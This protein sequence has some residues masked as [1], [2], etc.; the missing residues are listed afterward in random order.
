[1]SAPQFQAGFAGP[2]ARTLRIGFLC[3]HNPYDRSSF[4]GAPFHAA[5]ALAAVGGVTLRVIGG[6]RPRPWHDRLTRRFR[7]P[8]VFA[9]QPGE[10]EDLDVVVGLVA[11]GHLLEAATL[12]AA[13]LVHLTDATPDF[14][15][16]YYGRTVP[17]ERDLAEAKALSVVR[18]AVYSSD[19]MARRAVE[20]FG[21]HLR[22][23]IAALPFGANCALPAER[24]AKPQGGPLR[25]LWVGSQWE[26][27]GGAVALA[28]FDILRSRGQ[29][30]ELA[31]VG[32]VPDH[33][34][35][36][37]GLHLAGWL[38]KNR[39]AEAAQ[40]ADHFAAANLFILPTQA[41]CTPMVVAEAGAHGT[42]V[43]VTDVGGMGSLVAE[44]VNGRML[45]LEAGPTTWA[46]AIREMAADPA[47]LDALGASSF[48]H[49]RAHLTWDAWAE[50]LV[51]RL[52]LEVGADRLAAAAA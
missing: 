43:L 3:K 8:P 26:R 17:R 32:Q 18:L 47:A 1:M 49:V 36:R 9:L 12:T 11:T 42:P 16:E 10:F 20:E 39:P 40:L 31:M 51:A 38:D 4:S 28:A 15:R 2:L 13:P 45:P 44:G 37:P 24:P 48:A 21:P 29:D 46:Q 35:P 19:Y 27:K 14:L 22:R 25:L 41:D 34:R 6:H 30:V 7:A 23:K 5:R 50:A 52:R 33:V